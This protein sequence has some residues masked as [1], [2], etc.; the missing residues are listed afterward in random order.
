M[1][2]GPPLLDLILK[3]YPKAIDCKDGHIGEGTESVEQEEA[4][5]R[6]YDIKVTR[7]SHCDMPLKEEYI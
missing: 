6:Y 3:H 4:D 5:D 2:Y 1:S 7:C